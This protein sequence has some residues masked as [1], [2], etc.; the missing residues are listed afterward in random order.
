VVAQ[1]VCFVAIVATGIA[2]PDWLN[3][4]GTAR[5]AVG[6]V[7]GAAGI[8]LLVAGI[9]AL[10]P[11]L[12]PYPKPSE[13]STL[14]EGGAYRLVRHPI[15]GGFVL[16]GIGWSLVTSPLAFVPTALLGATFELKSR[17][18]ETLLVER[19]PGYETYRAR[20]RWRLVPWV[21]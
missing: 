10:G 11:S 7:I 14:R 2:G 17:L 16:M 6:W 13:G 12:T 18:E 8:V 1:S 20:V 4:A 5:I 21:H 9:V 3:T 15:Y 19:Y